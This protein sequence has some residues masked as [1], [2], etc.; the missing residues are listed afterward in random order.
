[1]IERKKWS[2]LVPAGD[3]FH[4]ARV[5]FSPA[6]P[7]RLHTHDFPEIFWIEKGGGIHEINGSEKKLLCGDL[8]F[9]RAADR[10]RLRASNPGGFTLINIAFPARLLTDLAERHPEIRA[11]HAGRAALPERRQLS[12]LQIQH[13]REEVRRLASS[14]RRRMPCER[15]LLGLYGMA[16][17]K[18]TQPAT[19]ALP[20]WLERARA[21]IE[22]PEHFAAGV[23][24][25]VK[26]CG[27]SPEYVARTCRALLGLSPTELVN[28][29]RMD[30]AARE[31]RLGSKPIM[32]ICLE[33]GF[34]NLAHFYALFRAAYS[35]TPRRYR[36]SHQ[37]TVL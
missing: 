34:E 1:M 23:P 9:I 22:R 27:R 29:I 31:L 19:A 16:S 25:F 13:L 5:E 35:E 7:S 32:D 3:W 28:H 33:C 17:A 36:L 18:T 14:D 10:H 6:R 12:P 8:I 15:F 21:V 20:A 30:H 26:L 37:Q 24:A 2:A 4:L 11:L